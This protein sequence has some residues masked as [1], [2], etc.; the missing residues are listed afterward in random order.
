MKRLGFGVFRKWRNEERE[1]KELLGAL[2]WLV[3]EEY[4]GFVTGITL[5][6]RE[7]LWRILEFSLIEGI[8]L[9]WT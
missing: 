6:L 1:P 8:R 4:P 5:L 2:L 3:D 9:C 7:E